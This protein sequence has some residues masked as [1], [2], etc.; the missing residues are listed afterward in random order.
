MHLRLRMGVLPQT[1]VRWIAIET[2]PSI[3]GTSQL[4]QLGGNELLNPKTVRVSDDLAA[5]HS[6]LADQG[7]FA[8]LEHLGQ[9]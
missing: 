4:L 5:T 6:P 8:W 3:H 9:L 7:R 2:R 1:T